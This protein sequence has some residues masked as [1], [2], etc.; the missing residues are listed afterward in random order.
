METNH[1]I[2]EKALSSREEL[3][4][5]HYRI[6]ISAPLPVGLLDEIKG[7]FAPFEVRPGDDDVVIR[8]GALDQPAVRALLALIWDVGADLRSISE[9]TNSGLTEPEQSEEGIM[10]ETTIKPTGR[11]QNDR[12]AQQRRANS[13]IWLLIGAALLPFTMFQTI[14]PIA[15]WLAP[16]FLLRFVRTKRARVALPVIA[17]VGYLATLVALRGIWSAP[18]VYFWALPGLG[19][20]VP[21]GADKLLAKRTG[22]LLGSLIL[23]SADT[24]LGFLA[25]AD[26][27]SALASAGAPGYTQVTN[28]PLLQAAS[29]VG[30]WGI[31]FVIMWTASVVNTW[32][33]NGFQVKAVGRLIGVW[34]AVMVS[35]LVFGS[36]RLAFPSSSAGVMVAA[37]APDPALDEQ[38]SSGPVG[39]G[40]RSAEERSEITEQ[41]LAPTVDDL[42]QQTRDAAASGAKIV[43]WSEA[44]AFVFAEEEAQLLDEGRR[45]AME[46]GIYLEMGLVSI[47]PTTDYPSNKNHSVLFGPDGRLLWDYH[48]SSVVPGDG[49]QPGPG[50]VPVVDTP[51]GRLAVVICFD[52]DFPALVRQAGRAGADLL[53]VPSSDWEPIAQMHADMAVHRAVENGLTMIRPTR[54]GFSSI[55]DAQG[56]T[57]AF[58]PN[59]FQSEVP[60]LMAT[61]PVEGNQTFYG[62]VGDVVG[63]ASVLGL[64]ALAGLAL[65]RSIVD[66]RRARVA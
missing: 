4:I 42:F 13:W 18:D 32:W 17:I 58:G 27:S 7:R 56:R 8:T 39:A 16:I 38:R 51:Y 20:I 21:Y 26:P 35:L 23:P 66:H 24:A 33:D 45:V 46:E 54:R 55:V 6:E 12:P 9:D 57:L 44:A 41:Y 22:L 25:A 30:M 52:A 62:V 28:L 49:N 64:A 14:L 34:A 10:T 2:V 1:P 53:L 3:S 37:V 63:V 48:K 5:T 50:V 61:V 29:I 31:G 65:A 15:A 47:L 43:A 36:Y 40:P 19:A 11:R 60:P 59:Y